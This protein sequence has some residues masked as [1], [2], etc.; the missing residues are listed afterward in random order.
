VLGWEGYSL[1]FARELARSFPRVPLPRDY[2]LFQEG[3]ELGQRLI[4][5]HSFQKRYP[6]DGSITIQGPA[7]PI[8]K[9][10]YD[11]QAQR[12]YMAP[13]TY[14][15]PVSLDA[16]GYVVSGYEVLRQWVRRRIGLPLD[17]EIQS[18]LLDVIW[19]IEQTVALRPALNDFGER[20]LAAPHLSMQELG[21]V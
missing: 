18:Q 17:L 15:A 14:A 6:A 8:E 2:G 21:L 10:S 20:L 16:W 1:H 12:L 11:P 4:N 13:E 3:M 19:A 7:V 5:W 9:G